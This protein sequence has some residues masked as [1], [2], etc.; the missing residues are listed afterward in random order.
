[1]PTVTAAPRIG[2]VPCA[3]AVKSIV[4]RQYT[5]RIT[6][7]PNGIQRPRLMASSLFFMALRAANGSAR[8]ANVIATAEDNAAAM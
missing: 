6:V 8:S 4:D 5:A 7:A 2:P 3:G 1:M